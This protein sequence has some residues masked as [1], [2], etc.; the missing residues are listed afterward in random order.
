MRARLKSSHRQPWVVVRC[1]PTLDVLGES[2]MRSPGLLFSQGFAEAV[3]ELRQCYDVIV[4]DGPVIGVGADHKPLDATTDG[5][6][7]V[8]RAG[9]PLGEALDRATRYFKRKEFIAAVSSEQ[10]R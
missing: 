2:V 7:F 3:T 8:I 4:A 10:R 5:L 6:V 9:A 1:S